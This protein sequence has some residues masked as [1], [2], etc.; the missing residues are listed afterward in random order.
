MAYLD[1]EFSMAYI[2]KRF[3]WLVLGYWTLPFLVA[4]RV[5]ER[6]GRFEWETSL[7]AC[8]GYFI[9]AAKK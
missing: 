2:H 3:S 8:A 1:Y 4:K 5:R 7:D 9:R 6:M